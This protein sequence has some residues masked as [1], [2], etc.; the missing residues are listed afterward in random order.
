MKEHGMLQKNV[1]I[2]VAG[3]CEHEVREDHKDLKSR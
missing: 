1:E 2:M 3:G